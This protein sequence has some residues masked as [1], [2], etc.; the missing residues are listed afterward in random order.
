VPPR[1]RAARI[2]VRTESNGDHDAVRRLNARAFGQPDEARLVDALRGGGA[3]PELCLVADLG[4]EAVGHIC[5]SRAILDSGHEVLALAP[6]AV[7]P[8]W[9]RGGIGSALLREGLERAAQGDWA[10]VVVVGHPDF[11]PRFGFE[12]AAAL[13]ISPPGGVPAEAWMALKLPS[14]V[15]EARGGVTYAPPFAELV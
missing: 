1:E 12:P 2:A 7:S 6:M 8:E 15:A 5:F 11:Y 4:G 10:A 9:Q 14:W 3:L 13:G